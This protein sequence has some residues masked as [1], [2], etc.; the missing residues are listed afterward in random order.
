MS[1]IP[2]RIV[3]GVLVV[4][5]VWGAV[6]ASASP[7]ESRMSQRNVIQVVRNWL[8]NLWATGLNTSD[9]QPMHQR[10]GPDL[11]PGGEPHSVSNERPV[12]GELSPDTDPDG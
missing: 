4:S 3:A 5:L 9:P 7:I 6:P 2:A 12:R 8:T 11:D 10:L 1:K